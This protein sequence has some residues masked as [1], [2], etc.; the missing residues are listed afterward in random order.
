M[1]FFY[2]S[3][4]Y[5]GN[6]SGW[7]SK[8]RHFFDQSFDIINN[9]QQPLFAYLTTMQS[10]GPFKNYSVSTKEQ[11]KFENSDYS[12]LEIDYLVSI[13]EVD[14]ALEH[15]FN[16][17]LKSGLL[18]NTILLIYADHV[19]QAL[20]YPNCL[21]ECIPLFIY[22]M[23]L[24]PSIETKVGSHLDIAPTIIDLLD[25]PEPSGWL[26]TSLFYDGKKTVLFNDFTAI[27]ANENVLQKSLKKRISNVS[28]LF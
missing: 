23:S 27:E 3:N 22:H 26:G 28:R 19:G 1:I 13:H 12:N 2:D 9:A 6:A 5:S 4:F 7:Y 20:H 24:P 14:R 18:N 11:F 21:A 10:H 25:V 8:D 16:K 17:L 15:F